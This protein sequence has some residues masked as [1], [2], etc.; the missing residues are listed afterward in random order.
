M[1]KNIKFAYIVASIALALTS[2]APGAELDIDGQQRAIVFRPILG[3]AEQ[4]RADN[5][6]SS[7]DITEDKLDQ[8]N[9]TCFC[10]RDNSESELS[11]YFENVTF[12]KAG[13]VF[14]SVDESDAPYPLWWPAVTQSLKFMAY[15][16]TDLGFSNQTKSIDNI[17]Y[18]IDKF[19]VDPEISNHKDFIVAYSDTPKC[20]TVQLNFKHLLSRVVLKAKSENKDYNFD[21]A[22]VRI[23]YQASSATFD[24]V[25]DDT[26]P[27]AWSNKVFT[28]EGVSYTYL[29]NLVSLNDDN[30]A[31]QPKSIMGDSEVAMVIPIA[32]KAWN[33]EKE[34]GAEGAGK[35]Y[36][37]VLLRATRKDGT[38]VYPYQKGEHEGLRVMSI[39]DEDGNIATDDKGRPLV[40]G[41]AAV[42]VEINWK[43]GM[44]Y[45][46]TLDFTDGI[47]R[48]DPDDPEPGH[49][50]EEENG[51][52]RI[53]FTVQDWGDAVQGSYNPDIIVP[54]E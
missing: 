18:K 49:P 44:L 47:G 29:N 11:P 6:G 32:E 30:I 5:E 25:T 33:P 46:Y 48:H 53:S 45:V 42:P 43:H 37:S 13:S 39:K 40:F 24:F 27:G 10:P 3:F 54:Y 12:K 8:F 38:V 14:E 7:K 35:M 4:S 31:E 34:W 26:N 19:N 17:V 23:G 50:I 1:M 9:V 22:G 36:F 41:W 20:E 15:Y 21:I 51:S 16:P 28:K 52:V 2:C